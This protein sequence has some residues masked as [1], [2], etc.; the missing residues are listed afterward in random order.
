[1]HGW[2]GVIPQIKTNSPVHF[3]SQAVKMHTAVITHMTLIVAIDKNL[4]VTTQWVD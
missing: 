3:N 1:M 2:I 4:Q